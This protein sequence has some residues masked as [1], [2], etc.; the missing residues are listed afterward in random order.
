MPETMVNIESD[1]Q[2]TQGDVQADIQKLLGRD[3]KVRASKVAAQQNKEQAAHQERVA[4]VEGAVSRLFTDLDT[5]ALATV[6]YLIRAAGKSSSS[7]GSYWAKLYYDAVFELPGL[8]P[9]TLR[10]EFG[11]SALGGCVPARG[12]GG[13]WSVAG[14]KYAT[15][16]EALI[17][18]GASLG[19]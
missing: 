5:K 10:L 4:A 17:A 6:P 9:I 18:A 7:T 19:D 2:V 16:A 14:Q 8:E 13:P 3:H 15:I 1:T 12:E 11:N